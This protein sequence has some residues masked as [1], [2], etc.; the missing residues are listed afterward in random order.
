MELTNSTHVEIVHGVDVRPEV[1]Y[2]EV[3]LTGPDGIGSTKIVC[4]TEGFIT[5]TFV[6]SKITCIAYVGILMY[7]IEESMSIYNI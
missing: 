4:C 2:I 6:E 7:S 5:S 1:F 3:C